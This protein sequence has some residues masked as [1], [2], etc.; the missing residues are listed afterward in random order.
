MSDAPDSSFNSRDFYRDGDADN[1][2]PMPM[3]LSPDV[4]PS[5]SSSLFDDD[6]SRESSRPLSEE[7]TMQTLAK[8]ATPG[9]PSDTKEPRNDHEA[10]RSGV[11]KIFFSSSPPPR[12]LSLA[13]SM[14]DSDSSGTSEG[15]SGNAESSPRPL[16]RVK[17]KVGNARMQLED[18]PMI[19]DLV[20]G[21]GKLT[22]QYTREYLKDPLAYDGYQ[23]TDHVVGIDP[24]I[25]FLRPPSDSL[26][27]L[28]REASTIKV[29]ASTGATSR[30]KRNVIMASIGAEPCRLAVIPDKGKGIDSLDYFLML[31]RSDGSNKFRVYVVHQTHA[32][33]TK[34]KCRKGPYGSGQ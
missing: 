15:A 30:K 4:P 34:K 13:P 29:Y 1:P 17:R 27:E 21:D 6:I 24:A 10:S 2:M 23:E 7:D 11:G 9:A 18:P 25:C 33:Q 32:Y 28:V 26:L 16:G 8:L 14:A 12:S 20:L 5:S 19:E 22:E 3:D 31:K